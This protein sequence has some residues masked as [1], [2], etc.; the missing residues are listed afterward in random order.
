MASDIA[1]RLDGLIAEALDVPP[2][3][4][5]QDLSAE[6]C[7]EW[8]SAAHLRLVFAIEEAFARRLTLADIERATSR[9]ALLAL[10][11]RPN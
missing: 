9:A 2:G 10:L 7:P 11:Q 4:V 1:Q 5:T 3:R 6:T 8:D